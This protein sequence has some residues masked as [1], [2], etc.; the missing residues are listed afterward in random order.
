M[1]PCGHT[2]APAPFLRMRFQPIIA[3]L[4]IIAAAPAWAESARERVTVVDDVRVVRPVRDPGRFANPWPAAWEAEYRARVAGEIARFAGASSSRTDG[5]GE[6]WGLPASIGAFYAGDHDAALAA[7]Q[8]T[9]QQA[10]RDHGWTGGIDLYW[11]F[12][13]K[14]QV[15]KWFSFRDDFAPDYRAI[16]ADAIR[17]WTA[18][19]PRPSLEYVLNLES[20]EPSVRASAQRQLDAMWRDADGLLALAAAAEQE[21]GG[22]KAKFAAYLRANADRIAAARPTDVAGWRAWWGAITAGDWLIFEEYERRVNPN[23]H[24][25]Y[26]IGTGPVGTAWDPAV[27]GMRADARNTDNLR[28]MRECAVYLFAE[29][30]GNEPVRLLY[31]DR[32]RRTALSFWSV[33]NG[34]WDSEGYHAHVLAAYANLHAFARDED[35]RG[36]AKAILDYLFTAAAVKYWRGSWGGP[37]KRDYGNVAP[38]SSAARTVGMFFGDA[39][40]P[41]AESENELAFFFASG[42]RPPA[43]VVALARKRFARPA[44]L[45]AS[46][47]TYSNWLPGADER[48]AYHETMSWGETWQLGT[49][50]EGHGSDVNGFKLLVAAGDG[51]GYVVPSTGGGKN[52]ATAT[53][54]GDRIAHCRNLALWLNGTR[55]GKVPFNLLVPAQASVGIVDGTAFIRCERTW[56][57]VLPVNLAFATGP[58]ARRSGGQVLGAVGTGGRVCGFAM[59]VGD[60]ASHGDWDAFVAAVQGKARLDVSA[61]ATGTVGFTGASGAQVAMTWTGEGLPA[62]RRD[63]VAHDWERHRALWRNPAGGTAPLSLGWKERALVVEA[64]GCRFAG[65]LSPEG[66]YTWSETLPE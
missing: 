36:Y 27:R 5:E 66:V 56:I 42:Y 60:A 2:G 11:A 29:D 16:F 40:E 6:K 10:G 33:G 55:D 26:G 31:E 50:V 59:E 62:V 43:A 17:A 52:P 19:D 20:P 41:P 58:V 54:G 30:S 34:E 49:L 44:E 1:G 65:T 63:G 23:P 21:G 57:A 35:V 48:P 18:S 8:A 51:A 64:G 38:W 37:V 15:C 9:D 13:L 7:M 4:S 46:H 32:L 3:A 39:P 14:G 61:I 28:G 24:P 45:L 12:T 53:V 25:K 22:N 47:P